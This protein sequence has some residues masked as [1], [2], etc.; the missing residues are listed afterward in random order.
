MD[1]ALKYWRGLERP[2]LGV[3]H[4]EREKHTFSSKFWEAPLVD[5]CLR[6]I[7]SRNHAINPVRLKKKS[8]L[9]T[10][11]FVVHYERHGR[12]TDRQTI[13]VRGTYWRLRLLFRELAKATYRGAAPPPPPS[14]L[15]RPPSILVRPRLIFVR[16]PSNAPWKAAPHFG[17]TVRRPALALALR[18][19]QPSRAAL[20]SACMH[21]SRC[22]DHT[23][24]TTTHQ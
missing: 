22:H 15:V 14:M 9:H 18:P 19:G 17:K 1:I 2:F 3:Q 13:K 12:Q 5:S 16:P 20:E 21:V 11:P 8:D 24:V 10:P 23:S 7:D 6:D 4:E